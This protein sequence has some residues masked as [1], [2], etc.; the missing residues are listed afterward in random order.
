MKDTHVP[1]QFDVWFEDGSGIRI[2]REL[3]FR[4]NRLAFLDE[5]KELYILKRS[6]YLAIMEEN[7]PRILK[8]YAEDLTQIEYK[9]QRCYGFDEKID[10]HRFWETPK[11]ICSKMDN[12]EAYP[13]GHYI[14][15]E[16]CM[17]H[18]RK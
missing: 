4:N 15:N 17:L 14:R 12:M 7:D 11:C 13:Y 5:I 18:G 2:N 9:L 6:I 1:D 3:L 16:R 8:S 10:F